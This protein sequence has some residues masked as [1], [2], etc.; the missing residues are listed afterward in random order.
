MPG[1]DERRAWIGPG[2]LLPLLLQI[3]AA[4]ASGGPAGRLIP[5]ATGGSDAE[6]AL[7]EARRL[8][9]RKLED[10]SCRQIF[11]D[12]ADPEGSP[13]EE[14]LAALALDG[15]TYLRKRVL[16]YSGHGRAACATRE[17]IAFTSP[18]SSVVF[19]CSPQFVEKTHRDLGLAAVLLI[20]EE[21]H[22]LGLAENPPSSKE[23][24]AR[25]IARCGK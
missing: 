5:A 18:G 16:F 11:T 9:E 20:H 7:S 19:V 3:F 24:T 23:I 15:A 17:T 2:I 4:T 13:L 21:L 6:W 10:P 25:V 14:K 12:F 1:R 8:A 22:S